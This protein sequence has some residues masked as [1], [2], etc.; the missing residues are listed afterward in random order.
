MIW[1]KTTLKPEMTG[2]A[3]KR[4]KG[5][6]EKERDFNKDITKIRHTLL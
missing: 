1:T 2:Q 5:V 4:V 6:A 3:P